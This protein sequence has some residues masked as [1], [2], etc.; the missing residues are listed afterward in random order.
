MSSLLR[1]VQQL[2]YLECG[3]GYNYNSDVRNKLVYNMRDN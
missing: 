3:F 1:R 2:T